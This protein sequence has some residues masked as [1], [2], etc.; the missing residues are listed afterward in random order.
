MLEPIITLAHDHDTDELV[1]IWGD[2]DGERKELARLPHSED[3][4][5]YAEAARIA[6]E[7]LMENFN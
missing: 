3:E 5:V 6:G 2:L 7:W 1:A 4:N